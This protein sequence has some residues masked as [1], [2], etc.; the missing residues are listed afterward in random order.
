MT[1]PR[2]PRGPHPADSTILV[3]DDDPVI[4]TLV[5]RSL[6]AEGFRVW[7]ATRAADARRL[8]AELAEAVDLVLTDIVMPEGLGSE[9]A[10]QIGSTQRWVRVLFMSSYS[11]EHLL[12]HGVDVPEARLLKKPF[13]AAQLVSRIREALSA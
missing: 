4:L 3:V 6:R 1:A 13:V 8:L 11:R 10:L 7:T 9:L 12:K 5:E 2:S